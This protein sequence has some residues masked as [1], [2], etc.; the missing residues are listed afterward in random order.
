M[1][2]TT[3]FQTK[4]GIKD[5]WKKVRN[6]FIIIGGILLAFFLGRL[7]NGST[8]G[9]DRQS[10]GDCEEGIG[11][12]EQA[13]DGIEQ[14]ANGIESG[15]NDIEHNNNAIEGRNNEIKK[16]NTDIEDHNSNAGNSIELAQQIL[17]DAKNR[18]DNK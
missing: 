2:L 17:R 15:L 1:Q 8:D 9:D 5:V 13:T 4:M 7:L 11:D 10:S 12:I 18:S 14:V 3:E 6:F 16:L